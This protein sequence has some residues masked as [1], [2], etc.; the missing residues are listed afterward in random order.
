V[1]RSIPL[2]FKLGKQDAN[3]DF[4]V[5]YYGSDFINSSFGFPPNIP[6]PSYPDP[7]L[8]AAAFTEPSAWFAAGAGIYDGD[9]NGGT[10]GLD[11]ALDGEGGSFS[12]LEF[13]LLPG[14]SRKA[15]HGGTYRFGA[16]H[17]SA[18]VKEIAAGPAAGSK[19]NN[20]GL[21]AIFDQPLWHEEKSNVEGLGAFFQFSWTP[22]DR[23][24]LGLYYGGGLSYR[25]LFDERNEDV[26]GIGFASAR[27]GD[28]YRDAFG[29]TQETAVEL[30]YR[31]QW[32]PWLS[33]QP[34]LQWIVNPGGDESNA[35]AAGAR[36]MVLF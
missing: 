24:E 34:D 12:I 22:D 27:L 23:N 3:T 19:S 18:R 20:H 14:P 4:A 31:F 28:E 1:F 7:A 30:F 32:A 15:G 17:H 11:T 36:F 13:S 10:S 26:T 33:L 6:M 25:G 9:A 29:G 35:L 8:A 21:Y 16:W 5:T 2:R